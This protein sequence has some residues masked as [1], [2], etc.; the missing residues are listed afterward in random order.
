[1]FS[2]CI[3]REKKIEKAYN[4][5]SIRLIKLREAELDAQIQPHLAGTIDMI[6][7]KEGQLN[8]K[9]AKNATKREMTIREYVMSTKEPID[10]SVAEYQ[11]YK[12]LYKALYVFVDKQ[13]KQ[14]FTKNKLKVYEVGGIG[15][16][17]YNVVLAFVW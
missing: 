15:K 12:H 6:R 8:D 11:K 9:Y 3:S 14:G 7:E 5:E 16:K 10:E 17:H 13:N 2:C 4:A 1:M